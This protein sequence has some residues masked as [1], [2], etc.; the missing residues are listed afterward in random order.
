MRDPDTNPTPHCLRQV[1]A[2]SQGV[3]SKVFR[4]YAA[5]KFSVN[6]RKLRLCCRRDA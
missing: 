1:A 3:T 2:Y 4:L 5:A 6:G